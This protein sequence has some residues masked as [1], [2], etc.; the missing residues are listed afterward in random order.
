MFDFRKLPSAT[1]FA[2]WP[3]EPYYTVLLSGYNVCC[4]ASLIHYNSL[5]RSLSLLSFRNETYFLWLL[6]L[7]P[8]AIIALR[9]GWGE[10]EKGRRTRSVVRHKNSHNYAKFKR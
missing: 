1:A 8:V 4:A 2:M 6:L 3:R 7:L 10:V 9:V 5:A